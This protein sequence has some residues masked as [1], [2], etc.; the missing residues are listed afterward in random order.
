[1]IRKIKEWLWDALFLDFYLDKGWSVR[2]KIMN[3][4]SGD[5]LRLF[6]TAIN[7]EFKR[8][9]EYED[10]DKAALSC[11]KKAKYWATQMWSEYRR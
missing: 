2:F 1:M 9:E 7:M 6:V 10:I 4:I 11:A 3:L 8:F 5:M